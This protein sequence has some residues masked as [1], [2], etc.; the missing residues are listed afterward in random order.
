MLCVSHITNNMH[1]SMGYVLGKNLGY[2]PWCEAISSRHVINFLTGRLL[3]PHRMLIFSVALT[4]TPLR[5]PT[6]MLYRVSYFLRFVICMF[7]IALSSVDMWPPQYYYTPRT[8][9][10]LGGYTGFT[11]SVRPSVRLSV[12]PSV[13]PAC[14]V[15]SVSSTVMDGFFSY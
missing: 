7:W 3:H 5:L 4:G 13:R 1:C 14:R 9:K 10:L 12:R 15:R 6:V 2:F 8:T 11:P